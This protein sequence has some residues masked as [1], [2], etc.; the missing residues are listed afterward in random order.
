MNPCFFPFYLVCSELISD[1]AVV[2]DAYILDTDFSTS[3]IPQLY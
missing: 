3:A 2:S 1:D